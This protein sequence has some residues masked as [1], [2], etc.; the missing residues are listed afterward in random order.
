MNIK[1]ILTVV[2]LIFVVGSVGYM[3]V[4][5]KK[6]EVVV[7]EE[8]AEPVPDNSAIKIE[9]EDVQQ[10]RQLIV[11]YF[12]SD[13]R[14]VTCHKLENY[15]KEALDTYLQDKLS[16]KELVWKTVNIDR[17]ENRHNINDYKLL[18]KSV[19]LSEVVGGEE[20]RWKNLD[21]IWQLVGDKQRYLT[22]IRDNISSF[23]EEN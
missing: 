19:V 21:Q 7:L 6:T 14:C 13:K 2:L 1:N 22:Y 23:L 10:V 9:G 5:E 16:S 15:T 3:F 17:P 18:T 20:V 8:S 4:N 12:Y 11:Y